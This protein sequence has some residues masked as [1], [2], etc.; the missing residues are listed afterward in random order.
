MTATAL[1]QLTA[2]LTVPSTAAHLETTLAAPA[3]TP[4]S[5]LGAS[6]GCPAALPPRHLET[7]H[8]YALPPA[9]LMI[10]AKPSAAVAAAA[11]AAAAGSVAMLADVVRAQVLPGSWT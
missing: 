10:S 3:L 1:T 7:D 2:D 8:H 4:P 6:P 11:A 9:L 5:H